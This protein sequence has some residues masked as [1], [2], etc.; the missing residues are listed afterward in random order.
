MLNEAT[1]AYP[2]RGS[3]FPRAILYSSS[4][5]SSP[6]FFKGERQTNR[7]WL[8]KQ[9]KIIS[10]SRSEEKENAKNGYE[11]VSEAKIYKF[12]SIIFSPSKFRDS[13]LV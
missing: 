3:H 13:D 12:F 1:H 9:H 8:K 11:K 6:S 2:S 10:P 5:A 7:R 4:F